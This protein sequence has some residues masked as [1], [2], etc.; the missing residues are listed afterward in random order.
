[1]I[2]FLNKNLLVTDYSFAQ[3]IKMVFVIMNAASIGI[4]LVITV[5]GVG[6]FVIY[7]ET[8]AKKDTKK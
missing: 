3:K 8:V 4:A 6:S 5:V 1:M 7:E 2:F